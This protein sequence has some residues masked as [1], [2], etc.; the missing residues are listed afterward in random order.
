MKIQ[1]KP[2]HMASR[3]LKK[4]FVDK[5]LANNSFLTKFFFMS[6]M[7]VLLGTME[8]HMNMLKMMAKNINAKMEFLMNEGHVIKMCS[9]VTCNIFL[10]FLV[11]SCF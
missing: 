10:C 8:Q 2:L 1:T 11:F 5:G 6:Q 7:N 3:N 4:L 9:K